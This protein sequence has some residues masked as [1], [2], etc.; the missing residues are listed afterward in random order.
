[1][2]TK[3]AWSQSDRSKRYNIL[4]L[5]IAILREVCKGLGT[6]EEPRFPANLSLTRV[7]SSR[8]RENTLPSTLLM[9]ACSQSYLSSPGATLFLLNLALFFFCF[10]L[11]LFSSFVKLSP[12]WSSA[13]VLG[14]KLEHTMGKKSSPSTLNFSTF[15]LRITWNLTPPFSPLS[16]PKRIKEKKKT[17][18]TTC[19]ERPETFFL[20][21]FLLRQW[22][23]HNENWNRS[24]AHS[25]V[26]FTWSRHTT[27]WKGC[28]A[29][30]VQIKRG[31]TLRAVPPFRRRPSRE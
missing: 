17:P 7:K 29:W 6:D 31:C 26:T 20:W 5:S 4:V 3:N 30:P 24:S 9:R 11:K 23:C 21:M 13:H 14:L 10:L 27:L 15:V 8:G 19:R 2:I 25:G 16:I 12:N 28:V 18:R 1:M 22:L